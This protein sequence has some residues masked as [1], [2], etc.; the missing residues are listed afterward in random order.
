MTA[1]APPAPPC[2]G[3]PPSPPEPPPPLVT[4]LDVVLP[5]LVVDSDANAAPQMR[6]HSSCGTA[7]DP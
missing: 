2:P 6:W 4:L 3:E 5:T 7:S 1:P